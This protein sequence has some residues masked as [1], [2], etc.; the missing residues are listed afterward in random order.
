MIWLA[1]RTPN[2]THLRS[3]GLDDISYSFQLHNSAR[4]LISIDTG[5]GYVTDG[6]DYRG[7]VWPVVLL[8]WPLTEFPTI[9][10]NFISSPFLLVLFY[11]YYNY[12]YSV[13]LPIC[14]S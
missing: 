8:H 11:H 6:P 1:T 2:T 7:S 10:V 4:T 13:L 14:L 12:Y 5:C 3:T 9:F